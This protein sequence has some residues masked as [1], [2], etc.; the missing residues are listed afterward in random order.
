MRTSK[1]GSGGRGPTLDDAARDMFAW[2]TAL[3]PRR[4]LYDRWVE[5]LSRHMPLRKAKRIAAEL[6]AEASA[7][8]GEVKQ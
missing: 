3:E 8:V 2:I 5:T 1:R 4:A 7:E 6:L